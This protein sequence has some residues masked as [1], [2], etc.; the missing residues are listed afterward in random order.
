M[1]LTSLLDYQ[2]NKFQDYISLAAFY[3]LLIINMVY[4]TCKYYNKNIN[5]KDG[6]VSY[7]IINMYLDI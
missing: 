3:V 2:S 1:L 4:M 5:S 6:N 7:A